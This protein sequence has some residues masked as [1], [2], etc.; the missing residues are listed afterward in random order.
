M[1]VV[2][3]IGINWWSRD[4]E[5]GERAHRLVDKA[6]DLGVGGVCIPYFRSSIF[7]DEKKAAQTRKFEISPELLYDLVKKIQSKQIPVY[8]AVREPE[9]VGY[10][11]N[12]DVDGYHISNGDTLYHPLLEELAALKLHKPILLSTGFSTFDEINESTVTLLGEQDASTAELILLHST[13][14][15]PTA[16][17]DADLK[18]ILELATEFYP[19]YSGFESFLS[20]QILDYVAMAFNPV[21][22]MRRLDLEDRGGVE[23][24]Y[25]LAPD[26]MRELIKMATAMNAI[27]NPE[28]DQNGFTRTD[29]SARQKLWRCKE[30]DYLLPPSE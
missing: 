4:G 28:F 10:L 21:V 2:A 6:I 12:I 3:N 15:L 20:Y 19:L 1:K 25:S 9:D 26:Q 24:E 17:E 22:V 16:M 30:S 18:R 14:G 23:S 29:F 27:N 7:R 11:E 8:I 5:P 13:G